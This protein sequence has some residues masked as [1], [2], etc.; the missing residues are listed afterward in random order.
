[1]SKANI[2]FISKIALLSNMDRPKDT[3]S[4]IITSGL[5]EGAFFMSM[6][7]YKNEIKSKLGFEA[8]PGTLNIKVLEKD[9]HSLKKFKIIRIAGFESK[10]KKF[11]G[12]GCY[13]SKM[14]S[15]CGSIIVPEYTKHKKDIIEFIAPVHIKSELNLKDGD[16]AE[17]E[18][19]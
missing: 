6:P 18:L 16:C 5:G 1:M 15:I 2:S 8:Y 12:A 14:R 7:H 3:I 13:K 10:G 9:L 11:G 4:G 19:E 17:I